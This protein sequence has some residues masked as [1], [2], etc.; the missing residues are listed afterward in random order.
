[1]RHNQDLRVLVAS[2]YYDLATPFFGAENALSEDGVAHD[3]IAYTYY[4]VGH[5]IFVHEP[6]R[7]RFVNDVRQF[8]RN[9]SIS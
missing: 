9:W 7:V 8:I 4:E 6:S 2:G 3:R 1:M 5:L